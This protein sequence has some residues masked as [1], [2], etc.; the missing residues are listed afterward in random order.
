MAMGVFSD[1]STHTDQIVE[2]GMGY[3]AKVLTYEAQGIVIDPEQ[4]TPEYLRDNFAQIS[5]MTGATSYTSVADF[6]DKIGRRVFGPPAKK[7]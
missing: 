6:L 5:D 7:E 3:F 4:A 2:A 1:Q